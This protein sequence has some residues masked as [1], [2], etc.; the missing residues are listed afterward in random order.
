MLRVRLAGGLRLDLDGREI[1]PPRSR[2]GRALL[3]WLALHPG[4][5]ARGELAGRFWPDVLDTSARTSLRAALTELRA[6]LGP[7]ADHLV[8]GRETV[9]LDGDGLWV[10]VRAF[11]ALLAEGRVAE[12]VDACA[13][14][15]LSG[16]DE[17]WVHEARGA[18]RD[19]IA[20]ALERLAVEA[21]RAGDHAQAVR[22]TRA[23]VTLDPLAEAPNRRLIERLAAAGDRAAALAAYE[24]LAERLRATVGIAPSAATRQLVAQV[25][26]AGAETPAPPPALARAASAPFAGRAAEL[27]RLQAAWAAVLEDRSRRLVLV[28]GEPGIGKTALAL[29]FAAREAQAA[30]ATVALGRCSEEPLT[31]YEPFAE[32]VRHAGGELEALLGAG[33]PDAGARHRLFDA[34][35]SVLSGLAPLVLLLD[36]LQWADRPTLLL[37]AFILSSTRPGALLAIGTYREAELGR[38]SALIG[39]LAQL[40]RDGS[41]E[42]IGLRGL[43]RS[44]V[45]ALAR[46]RLGAAAPPGV[47]EA[48]HERTGG[49][50][51]FVEEVL[52]GLAEDVRDPV[53]E[54]VRQAVG[55]RLARLDEPAE[56]L[57]ALA[58]VLGLHVEIGVLEAV[59]DLPPAA[60][61]AALDELVRAHLLRPSAGSAH[62]VEFPHA[63]V[64][65][66]VYA[67]LNALRRA[68]LHRRCAEA[69]IGLSEERHLEEIAHHLYEAAG[70]ADAARAVGYLARAGERALAMLAY[71]EAAGFLARALEAHGA[72][73]PSRE[74]ALLVARGDALLRAGDA[75]TA[76]ECFRAAA[77]IARRIGE[78][79]LLAAAALGRAGLGVAIIDVGPERV[80]LLEEALAA[81]GAGDASLRSQLLARLAVELYYAPSRDRS[82]A[83]SADAV[84]AARATGDPRTLAGALN[85]RHVAL[86][87]PDRLEER[88]RTADE[89]IAVAGR[90]G[91]AQLELQGRNWRVA[92]LFERGDMDAWRAEVE[93]HRHLAERLRLPEFAW[94][95][96]LWDAVDALHAGRRDDAAALTE[97]ARA[98]GERAGDR[99]TGLFVG[100]LG[101]LDALQ[102]AEYADVDLDFV[103]EK[104]AN[105]PAGMSYRCSYAWVLAEVGETA[106]AREQLAIVSADGFARLHFDA[107]WPTSLGECAGAAVALG[108]RPAAARL[109][110]LL[111]PYAGRP[112]TA[113]RAI[114][115]LGAVDRQLGDL[116]ALLG[117]PDDAVRHYEAAVRLNDAMGMAPWA[118]H[119]RFGLAAALA[120]RGEPS[121][122]LRDEALAGAAALGL[123]G[124]SRRG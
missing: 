120:A 22:R 41:V 106:G 117:R 81:V 44:D 42:R 10:D 40:R 58:A 119:A 3:A 78:A 36:D 75:R 33:A 124:L 23:A 14:E 50:A 31:A 71:E 8:A 110:E 88:L 84:A 53:P 70:P 39:A 11:A 104:I 68:R 52:R 72:G 35:D 32:V 2:R 94:Y 99:N 112:L 4:P 56:Q 80:A 26:R 115:S 77:A 83:L 29:R 64:R 93:R 121:R 73:D 123:T 45:A 13:G 87:R 54:S 59:A 66:A 61:E 62:A 57:V 49:N 92:D 28:A 46:A 105:S 17:D 91:D 103:R 109:Y 18:H 85:A 51:F 95:A 96:T 20:E 60:A 55:A 102:R 21:A 101:F 9:A 113:G 16:M 6:A 19:R 27:E 69:L 30:G 37:L 98:A 65:E 43:E 34:V 116:A 89:M 107:N 90:A 12:A 67:E 5:H 76:G 108:D 7:G 118:V 1:A 63:L 24:Q 86:W 97:Q 114:L 15:L 100:M 47:A 25:R 74:G 82:E 48:V 111:A 122:A 79:A 38:H